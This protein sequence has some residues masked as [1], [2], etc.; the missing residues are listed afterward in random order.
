MLLLFPTGMQ[1]LPG[2][3]WGSRRLKELALTWKE[4]QC[5]AAVSPLQPMYAHHWERGLLCYQ[6]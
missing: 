4:Q 1:M 3:H 6:G 5:P 2:W